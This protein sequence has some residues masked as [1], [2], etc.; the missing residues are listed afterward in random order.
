MCTSVFIGQSQKLPNVRVDQEEVTEESA[1]IDANRERLLGNY[2]D[3]ETKLLSLIKEYGNKAVYH[4]ELSKLY[5]EMD[6]HTKSLESIKKALSIEPE[7]KW[8]WQHRTEVGIAHED[9]IDVIY[10][11]AELAKLFPDEH[12]Y[13]ES[14]AFHQLRNDE[15]GEAI[16]TLNKVEKL[17]GINFETTRQKHLIY[18][19]EG[20]QKKAADEL[21]KYLKLFPNDERVIQI[22]ASYAYNHKKIDKAI[23]Y[24]ERL[25]QLD[26]ENMQAKAALMTLKSGT[27]LHTEQLLSIIDNPNV[28]LDDKIFNL[29]P[30][31]TDLQAGKSDVNSE[32]LI[33]MSSSLLEQYGENA[34]IHALRGDIFSMANNVPDAISSYKKSIEQ[35]DGNYLVYESLMYLF[36]ET[37]NVNELEFYAEDAMDIFPNQAMP[38]A[39]YGLSMALTNKFKEATRSIEQA[40]IISGN[41][42]ITKAQIQEI[43]MQ[44]SNLRQ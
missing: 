4:Y 25:V 41:K 44:I 16:K 22:A 19:E 8:Y 27:G 3:A 13:L 14:M 18:E 1:F 15:T 28:S 37:N 31:L 11:Y 32:T 23:S 39:F 36:V 9:E 2:E 6:D 10:S 5:D 12:R 24:Y 26:D 7:N 17:V 40:K 33:E 43:E 35:N 42:A 20:E 21:D 29:I 30:I 38:H 34:K